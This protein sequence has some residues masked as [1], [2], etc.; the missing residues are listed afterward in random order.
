MQKQTTNCRLLKIAWWLCLLNSPQVWSA[1]LTS[2]HSALLPVIENVCV[3]VSV[4]A[5]PLNFA[6]I[7]GC[8]AL[9]PSFKPSCVA[10]AA[11][12]EGLSLFSCWS[13]AF[14]WR[15]LLQRVPLQRRE[16]VAA[17]VVMNGLIPP[18]PTYFTSPICSWSPVVWSQGGGSGFWI[19]CVCV[20]VCVLGHSRCYWFT[21]EVL[22]VDSYSKLCS[23]CMC[24]CSCTF[25]VRE[26]N[27]PFKA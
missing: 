21:P 27:L 18:P 1:D 2:V 4:C 9:L 12:P 14:K 5:S 13:S 26:I 19:L 11:W 20:C 3:C 10:P 23:C 16:T 7:G 22:V 8:A 15:C 24:V 25:L 17:P 6:L